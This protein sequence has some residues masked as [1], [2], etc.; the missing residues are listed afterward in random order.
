MYVH[1]TKPQVQNPR[2]NRI[3]SNSSFKNQYNLRLKFFKVLIPS[4]A[5]APR[6]KVWDSHIFTARSPLVKNS[7][8]LVHPDYTVGDV[9]EIT[10]NYEN[11]QGTI[12]VVISLDQTFVTILADKTTHKRL[13]KNVERYDRY[14]YQINEESQLKKT[15]YLSVF[16]Q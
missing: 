15:I 1:G 11:L 2:L 5:S 9:L 6:S 4:H 3:F 7:I 13:H 8:I 10:N 12:G 16:I 14:H